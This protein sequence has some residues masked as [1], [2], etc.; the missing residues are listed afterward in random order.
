ML[1]YLSVINGSTSQG[2][3]SQSLWNRAA[4]DIALFRTPGLPQAYAAVGTRCYDGARPSYQQGPEHG[5][6]WRGKELLLRGQAQTRI[7]TSI[8]ALTHPGSLEGCRG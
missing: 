6:G 5:L 1:E 7:P 3:P 8:I 2:P 4:N